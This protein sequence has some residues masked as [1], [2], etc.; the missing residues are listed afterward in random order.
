MYES[1][2]NLKWSGDERYYITQVTR[3]LAK[4][5]PLKYM[6]QAIVCDGPMKMILPTHEQC[7]SSVIA[8]SSPE[9]P[10][11]HALRNAGSRSWCWPKGKR[12]LESTLSTWSGHEQN[13]FPVDLPLFL[14]S[15]LAG[16]FSAQTQ[17]GIHC[18]YK[19]VQ[20]SMQPRQ[21]PNWRTYKEE[22]RATSDLKFRHWTQI[23]SLHLAGDQNRENKL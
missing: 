12:A 4:S 11:G 8:I 14:D 3:Q 7:Q 9:V 13:Q 19:S 2:Q 22:P 16:S 1:T 10:F 17:S 23:N 20:T 15:F 21:K 6:S 18:L 5:K